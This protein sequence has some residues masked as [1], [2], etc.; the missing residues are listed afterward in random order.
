MI[1]LT[2]LM[3]LVYVFSTSSLAGANSN[4]CSF[5]VLNCL[6]N[7]QH[8]WVYNGNDGVHSSA[9]SNYN[10]DHNTNV[11][12]NCGTGNCD[13]KVYWNGDKQEHWKN[14]F[15]HDV[16]AHRDTWSGNFRWEDSVTGCGTCD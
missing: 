5:K 7:K 15:C 4:S 3:L 9:Y 8:F 10:L 12:L 16:T 13:M 6:C 2:R 1:N 14:D 11:T